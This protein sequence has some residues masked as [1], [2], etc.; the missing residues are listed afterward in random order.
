MLGSDAGSKA[1][2]ASESNVT[3]LN[4]TGHV[5]CF[6]CGVDDLVDCLHGKIEGHELTLASSCQLTRRLDSTY[7]WELE[8][9]TGCKPANAAPTVR[10]ANPDSVIGLSMTLFSPNRSRSPLV[11]LYLFQALDLSYMPSFG[12][13]LTLHCTGRPLHRAR[14]RYR[15]IQALPQELH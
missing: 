4:P 13:T 8:C 2:R 7:G 15:S 9:T 12:P 11:T 10:P 6:G 1:V 3:R 5:V 14:T